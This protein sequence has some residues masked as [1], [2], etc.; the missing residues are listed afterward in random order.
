MK[1]IHLIYTAVKL[2]RLSIANKK[3]LVEPC[4]GL[5]EACYGLVLQPQRTNSLKELL[6]YHLNRQ[7]YQQ[8]SDGME[9]GRRPVE[10]C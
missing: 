3:A 4:L 9:G 1:G 8:G 2:N 6:H 10:P 7:Q 5:V